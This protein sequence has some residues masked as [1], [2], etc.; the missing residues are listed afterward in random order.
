[1]TQPMTDLLDRFAQD[2]IYVTVVIEDPDDGQPPV[3]P[4]DCGQR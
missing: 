4:K 1:M 3:G 2:S